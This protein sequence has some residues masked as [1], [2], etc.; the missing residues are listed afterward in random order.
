MAPGVQ[1]LYALPAYTTITAQ[2]FSQDGQYLAVSNDLGRIAIFNVPQI[3]DNESKGQAV[4]HFEAAS[5]LDLDKVKGR[6]RNKGC[7]NS[8]KTIKGTLL[9]AVSQESSAAILAFAWKDLINHTVRL[10]WS[11]DYS[12]GLLPTEINAIDVD[13]IHEKLFVVGGMGNAK[14][15]TKDFAVRQI[16]LETRME[17]RKPMLGHQ[18]YIHAVQYS[19]FSHLTATCGEDG[20]VRT[21]DV[22]D[23]RPQTSTIEPNKFANLSRP[24]LGSWLG[25]VS[26]HGDWI[27][28]G[29]GPKAS[30]WHLK[31]MTPSVI[32]ELPEHCQSIFITKF[33]PSDDRLIIGG[34]FIGGKMYHFNLNGDLMAEVKTTSSCLYSVEVTEQNDFKL[35][36][37]GGAS[38][39]IDLC[40]HNF[41]YNDNTITFP[42]MKI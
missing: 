19:T 32:P 29:G 14:E 21:W 25:D 11:I 7:V 37:A 28:T 18:G 6:H 42:T 36:S 20:T 23:S 16:D 38:S 33:I 8:L 1:D 27:I 10:E 22:R 12:S 4:F 13:E 39:K 17:T 35:L 5:T 15:P 31:T 26:L 3:I 40:C 9:V 34:Q 2:S 30:I 24:R 41:S